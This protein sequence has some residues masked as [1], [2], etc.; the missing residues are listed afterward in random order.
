MKSTKSDFGLLLQEG[1]N[2]TAQRLLDHKIKNNEDFV[3]GIQGKVVRV[4]ANDVYASW[5]N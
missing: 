1:L 4:K 2:L 5:L 3:F